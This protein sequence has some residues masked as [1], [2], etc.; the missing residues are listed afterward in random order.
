M[1]GEQ[2]ILV[3]TCDL[4]KPF[5]TELLV[6]INKEMTKSY[7]EMVEESP[8]SWSAAYESEIKDVKDGTKQLVLHFGMLDK[9]IGDEITVTLAYQDGTLTIVDSEAVTW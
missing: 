3:S 7:K 9:W 6:K 8:T 1:K 2:S 5:A 4:K